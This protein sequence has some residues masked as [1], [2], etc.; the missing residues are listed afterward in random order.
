MGPSSPFSF[1]S[2][3]FQLLAALAVPPP[4]N[5]P[6]ERIPHSGG[7]D[8]FLR[9]VDPVLLDNSC[10]GC[11]GLCNQSIPSVASGTPP[12]LDLGKSSKLQASLKEAYMWG[13]EE[14]L[15]RL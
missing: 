2:S 8:A 10:F 6:L 4:E 14:K 12:G 5:P 11:T 1:L 3:H 13:R 7:Q 15:V 9:I